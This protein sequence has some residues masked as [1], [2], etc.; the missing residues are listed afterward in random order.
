MD[1]QARAN[2]RDNM[3]I[4][5]TKGA[6]PSNRRLSQCEAFHRGLAAYNID[7]KLKP[8]ML[9][10]IDDMLSFDLPNLIK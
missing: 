4:V 9:Q 8:K 6:P 2:G 5:G 3:V 10:A 7:E 1:E